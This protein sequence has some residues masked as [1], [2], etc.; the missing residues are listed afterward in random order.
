[1]IECKISVASAFHR[2]EDCW[3]ISSL[4]HHKILLYSRSWTFPLYEVASK[5]LLVQNEAGFTMW[6]EFV[7]RGNREEEANFWHLQRG[8]FLFCTVSSFSF[9][10]LLQNV[11]SSVCCSGSLCCIQLAWSTRN[12]KLVEQQEGALNFTWTSTRPVLWAIT[13]SIEPSGLGLQ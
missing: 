4:H 5:Q 12:I 9:S 6:E 2:H 1:M 11:F 3:S 10:S 13:T 8:F 7:T